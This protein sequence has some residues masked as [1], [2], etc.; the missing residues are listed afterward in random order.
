LDVPGEAEA[1]LADVL[2]AVVEGLI[3]QEKI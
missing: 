2:W 3:E 1:V